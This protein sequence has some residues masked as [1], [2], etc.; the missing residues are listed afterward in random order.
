M[1]IRDLLGARM[2][3]EVTYGVEGE[4]PRARII[5]YEPPPLVRLQVAIEY[6]LPLSA[7]HDLIEIM[8]AESATVTC[9]HHI[10]LG[11]DD[12]IVWENRT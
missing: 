7:A 10:F 12:K 11:I 4:M 8:Q 5:A 1:D 2:R 6:R 9:G 3:V